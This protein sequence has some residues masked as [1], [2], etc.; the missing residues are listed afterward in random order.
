MMSL[1]NLYM[2]LARLHG[3]RADLAMLLAG[4]VYA[5]AFPPLHAV[6]VLPV[7]FCLL[8]LAIDHAAGW[9]GA[10]RR[11]FMFAMGLYTV[12]LYWLMYAIL[13]R[14]DDFWWLVPLASPGC[15]LILAP[16]SALSAGLSRLVPRGTGRLMVLSAL[17]TLTDMAR[18]YVFS[19]FPWNPPGSVWEFPGLAGDIMIQP[20]AWI[21]VDGLT[22]LTCIVA[23]APLY[24]RMGRWACLVL[25]VAW[26]G[27]GAVRFS[28]IHDTYLHNPE[29]VLVQG[30]VPETD[31]IAGNSDVAIF[32]RYLALTHQGVAQGLQQAGATRPVVFAWPE[33][34]FPGLLLEDDIARPMIMR[35][36][37]GAA[38][39]IIGT[40]RWLEDDHHWRNSMVALMPPDA[41]GTMVYDK[42]HLVPFGEYQPAFLPFHVVPGEGMTPGPGVR[43]WHLPGIA[44]VGPLI[45]Y[46]V[47]FSGQVADPH[48]RPD[49][50]MN[51]TND[52]WYGNSAGPRQHLAAVRLRAVEEGLPVA[53]AANTGISAVF[54]GRGHELARLGWDR[55]GVL[56]HA[57][58]DALPCTF[59][60]R[61][62]RLVPLLLAGVMGLCGLWRGIVRDRTIWKKRAC[63][64]GGSV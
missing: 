48:D 20:A 60:G 19:G 43:T 36:G 1:Y 33:S 61:Y 38:A 46:E 5:L 34:A 25:M 22:L 21:G 54:D 28:S 45:C 51:S 15:A 59:F 12:G 50:L 30:N 2:K 64:S 13:L 49:W 10:A 29:I 37:Q 41:A 17:W 6:V 39:G 55:Q 14:A 35:A 57:V 53:R 31:K 56:V 11:G 42:A 40:V 8:A 24:G 3:W 52:A 4:G 63:P 44:P 18:V 62:G 26:V 47:I 32:R 16:L 9:R 27:C 7:A 58:P 23:L